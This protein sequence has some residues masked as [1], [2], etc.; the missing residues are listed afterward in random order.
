MKAARATGYD[1]SGALR[2][3]ITTPMTTLESTAMIH[4]RGSVTAE[5]LDAVDAELRPPTVDWSIWYPIVTQID[6]RAEWGA[7]SMR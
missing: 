6:Q 7:R 3:A 5:R 2:A 1:H 4:S